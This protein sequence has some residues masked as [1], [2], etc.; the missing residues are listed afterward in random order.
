M[1]ITKLHLSIRL[2][3]NLLVKNLLENLHLSICLLDP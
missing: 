3:E 1:N 2:L